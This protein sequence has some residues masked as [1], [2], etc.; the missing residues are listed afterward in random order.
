[1]AVSKGYSIKQKAL[2]SYHFV[3]EIQ[4]K[5]IKFAKICNTL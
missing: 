3:L 4:E 5:K 2:F 1:M